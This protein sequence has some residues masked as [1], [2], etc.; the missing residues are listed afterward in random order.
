MNWIIIALGLSALSVLLIWFY[1]KPVKQVNEENSSMNEEE[2]KAIYH[3]TIELLNDKKYYLN[4]NVKLSEL[5][6]EI[7]YNERL[8]S[9]SINKFGIL[10][11]HLHLN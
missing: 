7:G 4:K 3:K 6:S 11:L 8:V 1:K 2:L 10:I 9:K 5:S